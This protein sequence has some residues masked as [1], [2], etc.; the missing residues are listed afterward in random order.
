MELHEHRARPAAWSE[1]KRN[2]KR[3]WAV[4]FAAV[5]WFW[6]WS[7]Y[8]L[9]NWKFL[10]V[11][12]YLRSCGIIVAVI[13]YFSE[14]GDRLKQKHYQAWQVINTAQGK[15]GN[16]GGRDALREQYDDILDA[17]GAGISRGLFHR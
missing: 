15:G 5:E 16:G 7:A 10:H 4:P 9:S 2:I 17:V 11:V 3:R 12:N 14:P 6:E 13:F 1:T 8:R